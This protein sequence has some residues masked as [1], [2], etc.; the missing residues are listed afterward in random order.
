MYR[1]VDLCEN[2]GI[3][4]N[5]A[6]NEYLFPIALGKKAKVCLLALG[7]VGG[8]LLT[9]LVLLGGNE[10]ESIGIFDINKNNAKRYEAE[11]N[12]IAYAP[13]LSDARAGSDNDAKSHFN[14]DA[15]FGVVSGNSAAVVRCT[16][17]VFAIE[18]EE[19]LFDC[20]IFIF[21][22]SKVVPAIGSGV[23]DVRMAQY[24][25]NKK[26]LEHYAKLASKKSFKGVFAVVSDPVDPLCKAAYLASGLNP[27]QF[28]GFGLGVMNARALYYAKKEKRFEQY[29]V[30]GRAFGPHGQDL[31]LANSISNYNDELSKELTELVTV[32]NL[33]IR[34]MGFKPFIAPAYSS[35][36]LSILYMLKGE[37]HYSSKYIGD[38]SD[39]AFLGALNKVADGKIEFENVLLPDK[40]FARIQHSYENLRKLD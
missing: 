5:N 17:E 18:N 34:E 11:M 2:A 19:E 13:V 12:Q 1:L 29:E 27:G 36:V 10:I 24:E 39:G 31:V 16:P 3:F 15:G 40:L 6:S 20:D 25:E 30:E 23:S 8:N 22:A 4:K 35:G 14:A 38:G 9:G 7:D 33:R 37:W 28:H 26:I 21:C 32:E